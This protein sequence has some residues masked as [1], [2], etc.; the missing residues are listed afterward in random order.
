MCGGN[1]VVLPSG[2]DTEALLARLRAFFFPDGEGCGRP[3]RSFRIVEHGEMRMSPGA[4]WIPFTAE[5]VIETARS[6]CRWEA[7]I[8]GSRFGFITVTDAYEETRGRLTVKL[9]GVIP[10]TRLAGPELDRGELQR[11]LASLAICPPILLN[12][13]SLEYTAVGPATLRVQDRCGPAEAAVDLELRE[14]GQPAACRAIRPRLVGK[15]AVLTPWSAT[16]TEFREWEGMHVAMRTEAA[17]EL[18]EG[19]FCYYRSD[20]NSLQVR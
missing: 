2:G 5:Q 8:G 3:V 13:R 20:I 18:P 16:G 10:T 11:Y 7:K 15:D 1:K 19:M 9:G 12:N 4:K 6:N 14:E 17:W